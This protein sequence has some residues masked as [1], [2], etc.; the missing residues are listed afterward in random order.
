MRNEM[1]TQARIK[2]AKREQMSMEIVDYNELIPEEHPARIIVKFVEELNLEGFYSDIKS[3]PGVAGRS[4]TDPKLLLCLW[5]YAT[6]EGIGSARL[7]EKL[8]ERDAAFRWICGGVGVNY[9]TLSDFRHENG[10][11]LDQLLT[12]IMSTF[13]IKG[14]VRLKSLIVDGTKVKASASKK[15]FKRKTRL[16]KI[17]KE[18]AHYIEELRRELDRDPNA[19]NRRREAA[20]LSAQEKIKAKVEAALAELPKVE[21]AKELAKKKVKKGTEVKE[22]KVSTSD[23]D[24]RLMKFADKSVKAGYNCQ[25]VMEPESYIV[26]SV[27][28]SQNGNDQGLLKPLIEQI[29][30]RY[31]ERP[32]RALVDSGYQVKQDII[33]LADHRKPL[34][35]YSPLPKKKE[36]IKKASLDKRKKKEAN[37]P[38]SLKAFYKRMENKVSQKYYKVR[39]RI[40][41]FNGILHNRMRRGFHL[42]GK[43]KVKSELLLQA[44]SHNIMSIH[45]LGAMA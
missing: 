27:D 40:E 15:S 10:A 5:L 23:P 6:L 1:K 32:D 45:R 21:A 43:D 8:C 25:I 12:D 29:D 26:V 19:G 37:Y 13:I 30:S 7:L 36:N 18:T 28:I 16:N 33:D 31:K 39:S 20:R 34:L 41:T 2:E 42:R 22:A 3:L 44:I 24:A 4:A 11:R 17:K 9:H 14:I 38:E 35:V